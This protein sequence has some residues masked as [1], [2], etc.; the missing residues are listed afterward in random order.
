MTD[1]ITTVSLAPTFE[2]YLNLSEE[3]IKIVKDDLDRQG[4]GIY[5]KKDIEGLPGKIV[6]DL[7]NNYV[8]HSKKQWADILKCIDNIDKRNHEMG[9]ILTGGN[10]AAPQKEQ[11]TV[12]TTE[13]RIEEAS[14]SQETT[15]FK[16]FVN[17]LKSS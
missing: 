1:E 2:M 9:K 11:T 8:V 14:A 13:G 12:R 10:D 4:L 7:L 3:Q 17:W 15:G 5:R 6:A 16:K